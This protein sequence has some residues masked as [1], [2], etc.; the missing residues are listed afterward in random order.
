MIE[1]YDV[2]GVIIC[3][4][5]YIKTTKVKKCIEKRQL[6]NYAVHY[7]K[8]YENLDFKEVDKKLIELENSLKGVVKKEEPEVPKNAKIYQ[9][10]FKENCEYVWADL[11]TASRLLN[12]GIGTLQSLCD[13]TELYQ[14][15]LFSWDESLLKKAK[16]LYSEMQYILIASEKSINLVKEN[17]LQNTQWVLDF[18]DNLNKNSIQI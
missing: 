6:K 2:P 12:I 1:L 4:D 3:N 10:S 7:L 15:S 5:L 14:D 11:E 16:S 9:W 8:E 18:M 17:G 13:K